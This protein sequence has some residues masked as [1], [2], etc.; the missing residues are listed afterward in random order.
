MQLANLFAQIRP[1]RLRRTENRPHS[2]NTITLLMHTRLPLQRIPQRRLS[3]P[4]IL[5]DGE[6][7]RTPEAMGVALWIG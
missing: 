4:A 5:G 3:V 6:V 1:Q 7:A 2:P